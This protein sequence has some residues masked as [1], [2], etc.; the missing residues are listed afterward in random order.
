M[1]L[2]LN[3][4]YFAKTAIYRARLWYQIYLQKYTQA[5]KNVKFGNWNSETHFTEKK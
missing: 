3:E 5:K 2:P 4:K 1:Y